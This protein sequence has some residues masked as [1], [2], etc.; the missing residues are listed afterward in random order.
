VEGESEEHRL[1]QAPQF[2][3]SVCSLTQAL[4]HKDSPAGQE[5]CPLPQALPPVQ[6]P[7]AAPAVPHIA[8]VWLE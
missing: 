6:A 2:S 5:H 1:P 8:S 4:S 7:H 3:L